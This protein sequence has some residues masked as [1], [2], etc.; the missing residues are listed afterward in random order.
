VL[1]DYGIHL[2]GQLVL[3]GHGFGVIFDGLVVGL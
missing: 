1:V 2:L 3:F